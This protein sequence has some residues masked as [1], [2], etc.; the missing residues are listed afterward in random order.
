MIDVSIEMLTRKKFF[1]CLKIKI[2]NYLIILLKIIE[3]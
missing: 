1:E 2:K 3:K